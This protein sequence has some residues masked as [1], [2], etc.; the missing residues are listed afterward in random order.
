MRLRVYGEAAVLNATG[1]P[2]RYGR[3]ISL[4]W[5]GLGVV[6]ALAPPAE[7]DLIEFTFEGEV[8]EVD[9]MPPAPW[10]EVEVGSTF[11]VRYI[12]DSEQEDQAPGSPSYGIYEMLA[13]W[14][15]L[16]GI[17]LEATPFEINI[18]NDVGFGDSYLAGF[19]GPF[20]GSSGAVNLLGPFDLFESDALPLDLDLDAFGNA[21]FGFGGAP[22]FDVDGTI[23]SFE[24]RVVPAPSGFVVLLVAGGL[25][26]RDE[27]ILRHRAMRSSRRPTEHPEH[28]EH[29]SPRASGPRRHAIL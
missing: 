18:D 3:A 11:S 17:E 5:M 16:D 19:Y 29:P 2:M 7:A 22:W 20:E 13:V 6:M 21:D 25:I 15:A 23:T 28:P 26:R 4:A 10:D 12:F 1:I 9:G 24:S 8:Y 14:V 27:G